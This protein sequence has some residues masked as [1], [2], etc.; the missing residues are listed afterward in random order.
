VLFTPKDHA[1]FAGILREA[2]RCEVSP[3]F[4]NLADGGIRRKKSAIDLVTDADEAA[5]RFITAE[6]A[7]AFPGALV[8]GE[9]AMSADPAL[10]AKLPDADLA[11]VIDPVDGTLNFASDLPVFAV[12]GAAMVRGESVAAVIHDP[13]LD[14]AAMALRGEGAWLEL[15]SGAR[16]DL[17][18]AKPG[19]LNEMTGMVSWKYFP[20]PGRS[21]IPATFS[22]FAD[23]SSLRCSGQEYRLAAAGHCHFLVYGSLHPWDHGPGTLLCTEAGGCV[24]Y[25][26]D[27]PYRAGVTA[28]GLLAAPDRASWLEIRAAMFAMPAND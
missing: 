22:R 6:L 25:L 24:R 18:V 9:E 13:N 14:D 26:H 11:F 4:R 27:A 12:M 10:L 1:R 23:V 3:R 15:A 5:E 19:P 16:R 7:K 20:E 17:A 8:I 21:A 28:K 2:A